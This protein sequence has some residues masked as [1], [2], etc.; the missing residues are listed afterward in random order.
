MNLKLGIEHATSKRLAEVFTEAT[1]KPAKDTNITI[2][3][4]L[5]YRL[6]RVE[7]S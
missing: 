1:G 3:E 7:V 6:D 4:W 5:W 2:D